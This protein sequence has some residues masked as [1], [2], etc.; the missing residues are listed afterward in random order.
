MFLGMVKVIDFWRFTFSDCPGRGFCLVG[1]FFFL[2]WG[3]VFFFGFF[4]F[5]GGVFRGVRSSG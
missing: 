2:V 1:F 3:L 4:V 5:C